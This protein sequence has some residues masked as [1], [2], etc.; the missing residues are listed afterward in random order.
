MSTLMFVPVPSGRVR[1]G[2]PVLSLVMTPRLTTDLATAG[3]A[4]WPAVVRA[5]GV[6]FRVLTRA[7]GS[8]TP[9]AAEPT[10]TL[11]STARSEVWQRFFATIGVTPFTRPRG[12]H[13]PV[14]ARTSDDATKVRDTYQGAAVAF[15]DPETVQQ[16]LQRWEGE[17]E[18]ERQAVLDA[19]EHRDPVPDFHR[20]VAMLREHPHVLRLLG[21]VVDLELDG[22][23]EAAADREVSVTWDASPVPVQQRWTR[24]DFDGTLFLPAAAGD[25]GGGMVDLT[26]PD[27]W[28]I[29]TFDVDGGVGKLR[30]AARTLAV[31]RSRRGEAAPGDAMSP[32]P[33]DDRDDAARPSLPPLRSAGLMLTRVARAQRLKEKSAQGLAASTGANADKVLTAED[34]VL[35]YRIDVRI[36]DSD[37]WFS[38]HRRRATYR[39]GDLAEIVVDDE[40]G[41]V[42]PHAAVLDDKGLRTDEVVARWDGWSLSVAR[43]RLDGGIST[44]RRSEVEMPYDFE[45]RYTVVPKSLLELEFGRVYQV[46]ARVADLAGG[47]LALRD[48]PAG[49][50]AE[51]ETYVRYEPIPPPR[52][53]PPVGLL[54][55]DDQAPGR[56]RIDPDVVGPGGSLERLVIRSDPDGAG[57]STAALDA[58]PDYPANRVRRFEA[59]VTTFPIAEQHGVLRLADSTGVERAS[60]AFVDGRAGEP[61]VDVAE[62]SQLPDPAALGLAAAVLAQPGLVE[63]V[64]HE[65]R[66]WEG[67]WPDLAGKELE[68]AA[69][70]PGSTPLVRWLTEDNAASPDGE[71]SPRVQVV[72]PPGCQVDVEVTSSVLGERIARFALNRFMAEGSPV[73]G[74]TAAQNAMAQGRHPL[75]SPPRRLTLTHA[76]RRP[77]QAAHGRVTVETMAR[78]V[79]TDNPVWGIHVASTAS[80]DVTASWQEWGDAPEP[81][82][83]SAPVAQL[84][85]RRGA[86]RLPELSHDFGD[87]K[88]RQVIF[89]VTSV[90]R[91]RDCFVDTDAELFRLPGPLEEVSVL[92]TARP[93]PPVVVSVVPAFAWQQDRA[94][95]SLTRHR[96]GGRLRVELARPW[97]TTGEGEALAVLVW[98]GAE[99]ELPEAVREQVTWC[100]R[101]PIHATATLPALATE[102][103][104]TGFQAAVDVPLA[105]GGPEV[106]ALAFPVF[107]H[108]NH[109]YADVELP[110]VAAA[111]YS[112]FVRLA[113]ARFQGQ[114]LVAPDDLR[115]SSVVTVEL[116]QVLP[117]RHLEVTRVA[118]GVQVKLS[119]LARLAEHQANRIFASLE[120]R[121]GAPGGDLTS[122]GLGDPDFPAWTRVAG[123]TTTGVVG[124]SL[125]LTPPADGGPLRLVVREVEEMR[126]DASVLGVDA[127]DELAHRTVFVDVVDLSDL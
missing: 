95:G 123:G 7:A 2:K 17:G 118:G 61:H 72:L 98:P 21:L 83:A 60:R 91:F 58:D 57:F 71:A 29:L 65:D 66:P 115:M 105:P 84:N 93:T 104:F 49:G 74:S 19:P 16:E 113:V 44:N 51:S 101:D 63:R 78:I 31:E 4:D 55:P 127:P 20:A 33:A 54:V 15:A 82:Q 114:S 25:I 122:L 120:R 8:T 45:V 102:S 34:L 64:V 47:G 22:V 107:F 10:V 39:I 119:G 38:L 53:V 99:D 103:Q 6:S 89:D 112:P 117:D 108:E 11:R 109:W 28:R 40:E 100:N 35:G 81:T 121:V 24:Y 23:P 30:G 106:R 3:M 62:L 36:Q 79:P 26:D 70:P 69:G 1:D 46:R 87:T 43:P 80:V 125:S 126:S 90:S 37:T 111:S 116:S 76:V 32:A 88:H 73:G 56:F 110:G 59:P 9:D 85:V 14:V 75:L 50:A 92:S 42:K 13:A 68:L 96:L 67:S 77:L 48:R 124:E 5:P 94:A 86:E 97:F 41:H 27:R 18:D 52:L 12:Y